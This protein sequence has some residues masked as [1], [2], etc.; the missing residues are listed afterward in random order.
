MLMAH[1]GKK[2]RTAR[3]GVTTQTPYDLLTGVGKVKELAFAKFDESVNAHVN[4][5]IDPTKGDQVV[6]GSVLLPHLVGKQPRVVVFAKG[7]R[8]EV[9]QKAGADV[10]GGQD[11]V[12]KINSGW[13]DF[14]FAVATPDMMGLVGKLAKILGPRGL[15]PNQK[16]GT[17]TFDVDKVVAELKGGRAFFKNDKGGLVHF[18]IGKVS[19]DEQKLQDNLQAF[20][21]ALSVAKPATSK[22]RFIRKVTLSSTMGVG[23][24]VGIEGTG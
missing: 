22:G 1:H 16:L 14:D 4:V 5:G 6:R 7:D 23:I 9:A 21:K 15:L 19:F 10:V 18:S 24:Q 8:V 2:Y 20:I 11:L 12:E 13:M 3:E 17:V